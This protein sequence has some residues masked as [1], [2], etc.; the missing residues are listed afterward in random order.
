MFRALAVDS[1]VNKGTVHGA[2]NY[3]ACF[4]SY[5]VDSIAGK[6]KL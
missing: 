4:D 6:I 2:R 1:E 5:E 3:V